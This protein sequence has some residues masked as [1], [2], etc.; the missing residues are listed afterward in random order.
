MPVKPK[1]LLFHIY[2][3]FDIQTAKPTEHPNSGTELKY[4]KGCGITPSYSINQIMGG[5]IIPPDEYSWTA[6]L[7]YGNEST[8]G[9]CGGSAINSRYVLTAAHCVKGERVDELGG[10]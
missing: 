7:Q 1:L 3:V 4:P 8:F 6:S 5:E 10:L 2:I 9:L